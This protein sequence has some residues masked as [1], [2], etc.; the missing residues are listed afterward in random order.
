MPKIRPFI[1]K[2]NNWKSVK[3]INYTT[4]VLPWGATEAH[5]Y[6]LPYGTDII[7]SEY[8]AA[9][10]AEYA[11]E[12]GA[13][14]AVLPAI[15]FG[16]N[17]G[18]LDINMVINMNPSTQH[19]ILRDVLA[20]LKNY[21]VKKFVILNS[22]G[23]N[24]FK[25]IL[26]ELQVEFPEIFLCVLNWYKALDLK[27]Y[28]D[29]PGDH[30]GEMETCLM[31]NIVPEIVLPV[32]DAGDGAERKFKIKG[33]KEGWAWAQREWTS[34]TKDTGVGDPKK[35]NNEKGKRFL[36]DLKITVGEFFVELDKADVYDLYE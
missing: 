7:Q 26:R 10:A 23:G 6:H 17:T 1:L 22:H 27:K 8:I 2:E 16:V 19:I 21:S 35:A 31:M 3:E 24:D 11:W 13:M 32:E 20:S 4:A 36:A 30:A 9:E 33:L 29:E 12:K 28:F 5:N 14:I 18:Q 34:I 25:Q 15:P